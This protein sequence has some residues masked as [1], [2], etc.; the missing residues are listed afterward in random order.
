MG[1]SREEGINSVYNGGRHLLILGAGA[2]IANCFHTNEKNNKTLPSMLNFIDTVGL[3]D[4]VEDLDDNLRS[5]NFETLFSNL[6]TSDSESHHLKEI[7]K[8][9]VT[10][11][12]SIELPDKPTIYDYLV[13]SL[14]NK[15]HIATFN[16]DPFLYQAFCRNRPFTKNLAYMSF[17]HGN[18]AIGYNDEMK[19][20]G[21]SNYFADKECTKKF[22]STKLLYPIGKKDY[23]SEEFIKTE[24]GRTE[25]CVRDE[26]TK[27]FTV[28]GYGAPASD[29]EAIKL[30]SDSWGSLETRNMEQFEIINIESEK[31]CIEKWK[32]FIHSHHYDYFNNYFDSRLALFPRRT[33]ESYFHQFEAESPDHAFQEQNPVPHNFDSLENMWKWF[34]P[35]IEAEEKNNNKTSY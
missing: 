12:S 7:E 8:R 5:E 9:V 27:I 18:V 31:E 26:K 3:R 17:L 21:P 22:E 1:L 35:L 23:N 29:V 19:I 28:F 32:K 33:F 6:F 30:L 2:S 34:E 11:F 16:W 14:R 4:I 20:S 10:Y 24:W 25:A 15:D 13:L